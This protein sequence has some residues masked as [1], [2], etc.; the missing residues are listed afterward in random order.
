M[1][2]A[3][4]LLEDRVHVEA[5]CGM[6][7][8]RS[9]AIAV[10]EVFGAGNCAGYLVQAAGATFDG[11]HGAQKAAGVL[12]SGVHEQLD[13]GSLLYHLTGIHDGDVVGHFS[14]QREVVRDENHG[15]AELG[16]KVVQK[17][18]DLLLYRHVKSGGGLVGNDHLGIAGER[19]CDEDTLALATGEL[20]RIALK[21]TGRIQAYKFQEFLGRTGAAAISELL[22][23][24]LDEHGGVQ[25]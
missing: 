9:E 16:L 18:D 8:T 10:V 17:L 7:R 13:G 11:E 21:G 2:G 22:H 15:E 6:T 23:L 5:H 4:D 12:V 25:G 24:I 1:L 19:H 20:V 3:G 14:H